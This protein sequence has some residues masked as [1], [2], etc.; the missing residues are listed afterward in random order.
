M[1]VYLSTYANPYYSTSDIRQ[2]RNTKHTT[3]WHVVLQLLY[4][5]VAASKSKI[6]TKQ[7]KFTPEIFLQISFFLH[8]NV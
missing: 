5:L 2:I 3:Y 8:R 4:G 7:T 6:T 1:M